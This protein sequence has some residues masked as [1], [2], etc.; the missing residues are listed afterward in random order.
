MSKEKFKILIHNPDKH[1]VNFYRSM[2]PA[3]QLQK[4]HSDKFTI[5]INPNV[6]WNDD[7]YLK[8]FALIS[9]HRTLCDYNEMPELIK[10]L[11]RFGIKTVLDIDDYWDVPNSHYLYET[12]KRENMSN[13]IIT[14]LKLVDYITTTTPVFA[15]FIKP[16]NKNVFVIE[17]GVDT[18]LD[19]FNIEKCPRFENEFTKILWLGGSSH[20]SDLSLM[21]DAF[22][23]MLNDESLENKYQL[24]LV[25]WDLRGSSVTTKIN[26][27]AMRYFIKDI[28]DLKLD[29]RIIDREVKRTNYNLDLIDILPIYI[30]DK[31]RG[32]ITEVTQV[33]I[34]PTETIWYKYEKDIFTSNYKLI[35]D[36]KY[37]NYL[38][39]FD[40]N[41]RYDNELL[42][43][44]YVRHKTQGVYNFAKNYRYSDICIA[45]LKVYG[46]IK[47]GKIENNNSNNFQLAKSN[48]K[49][50]ESAFHKVPLIASNI[51]TYNF[52]KDFVDGKNIVFINP[53]R[54]EKDWYKKIKR[55]ILNPNERQDIGESAYETVKN[56]YD[57]KTLTNKRAEYYSYFIEN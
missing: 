14:N 40:L 13:K 9:G 28:T 22:E 50:I 7:N 53:E 45:P 52:D 20:I 55:L 46:K 54:Q 49:V 23:L 31:Y 29:L 43:Q 38:M 12:L 48:L 3:I 17:N 8:Q 47:D 10:K 36:K 16:Y 56:K 35:K 44:P 42:E 24:H 57:L 51:P 19:Q 37:Y 25:G 32:K 1:G 15:N 27:E 4:D 33:P 18:T 41:E 5:E 30:K 26:E 21:T 2:Q 34:K 11:K 6:D 39:E